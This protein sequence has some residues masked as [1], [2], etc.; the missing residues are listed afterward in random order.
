MNLSN[1]FDQSVVFSHNQLRILD[2]YHVYIAKNGDMRGKV[3]SNGGVY[4][5]VFSFTSYLWSVIEKIEDQ[6]GTSYQK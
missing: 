4:R 3:R 1:K 6:K 5:V 2:V